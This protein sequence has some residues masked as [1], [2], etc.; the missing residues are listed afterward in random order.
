MV[1]FEKTTSQKK[2]NFPAAYQSGALAI[3]KKAVP[4]IQKAAPEEEM[5][6]HKSESTVQKAAAPDLEEKPS[7]VTQH[8]TSQKN[9]VSE[10]PVQSKENKTGMSD[11]LKSGIENLSGMNMDHVRVHYNSSQPA[12]LNALAYA[13]GS[14]IHVAPGQ[15]KHLPHE[16]WHVVQQAQGRVQ[17]T[18]Q[19]K[20]GVAVNDD[21]GLE[22]EA[23]VMGEK[24]IGHLVQKQDEF[25]SG[26]KFSSAIPVLQEKKRVESI[27]SSALQLRTINGEIR[28][29]K[30]NS[31]WIL[32]VRGASAPPNMNISSGASIT[33]GAGSNTRALYGTDDLMRGHLV[34]A[35]WDNNNDMDRMTQW[36]DSVEEVAWTEIE[37]E[38]E[39]IAIEDSEK[40]TDR[41]ISSQEYQITTEADS[42]DCGTT[43]LG[44]DNGIIPKPW[45]KNA[46]KT[47]EGNGNIMNNYR[48]E[49]NR[50][51]GTATMYIERTGRV[52]K[53]NMPKKEIGK[54]TSAAHSGVKIADGP[55]WS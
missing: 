39:K 3:Q 47:V 7:G 18:T 24:A 51:I 11:N 48:M 23:D 22:H 26:S 19:M 54:V 9:P 8:K 20:T 16:A 41:N 17:P 43:V 21:P 46:V 2:S 35:G 12:Q 28:T 29:K 34:K 10:N 5:Q 45:L 32:D 37:R 50:M 15:E 13:Q 1:G 33:R 40:N 44:A 30:D 4:I 36:N 14:D 38:A 49:L 6:Q 55:V 25:S 42:V 52:Q 53:Y 27:K 31:K